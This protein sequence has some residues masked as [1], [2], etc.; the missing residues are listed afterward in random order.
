MEMVE[1]TLTKKQKQMLAME[2]YLDL[3][4][5][6]KNF[7]DLTVRQLNQKN[8][9][10]VV[11]RIQLMNLGRSTL[12]DDGVSPCGC[13]NLKEVIKDLKGIDWTECHITSLHTQN[14]ATSASSSTVSVKRPKKVGAATA[15][16]NARATSSTGTKGTVSVKKPKK[17]RVAASVTTTGN[18]SSAGAKSAVPLKKPSGTAVAAGSTTV[19]A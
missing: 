5:G 14:A 10:E 17:A 1:E 13:P 11:S 18:A 19:G 4:D 8:L 12:Q 3:V 7:E 9:I 6:H 16:T 15:L 2:D